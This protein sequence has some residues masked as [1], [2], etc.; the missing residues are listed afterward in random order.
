[1]LDWVLA[2]AGAFAG[3][4]LFLFYS[5]LATRPGA[6]TTFDIVVG[7]SGIV[8]LLEATRRAVGLPMTILAIVFL[9]YVLGRRLHAR[10]DRAQRRV[11]PAHC[12]RTCG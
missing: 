11:A 8:L 3:A 9:A 2:F 4:Y 1:M 10:R 12:S 5:E 6:P 7:V